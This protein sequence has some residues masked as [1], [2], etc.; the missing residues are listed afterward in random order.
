MYV[1]IIPSKA[2]NIATLTYSVPEEFQKDVEI[3]S[4]VEIPF[5]KGDMRG[6]VIEVT[7][8]APKFR[9]RP[10][11]GIPNI[12]I[13][14]ENVQ[15]IKWI[16]EYY[17][18]PLQ[19]AAKLFLPTQIWNK[20][21]KLPEETEENKNVGKEHD[22]QELHHRKCSFT[23]PQK[24]VFEDIK[25]SK[26]SLHLLHGVTGSGKT[27]V[28]LHLIHEQLEQGKQSLILLPEISLTPQTQKYFEN[29]FGENAVT[30]I[31]SG[32]TPKQRREAWIDVY[33]EKAKIIIGARSS[34]FAPFQKLGIIVVDES[35]DQSFKQDSSP[36][37]NAKRVAAE[38]AKLHNIQ[39]IYG[40]ATPN[41]ETYHAATKGTHIELNH[42]DEKVA[43]G[44]KRDIYMVDMKQEWQK[45]NFSI[46]S[47]LLIEKIQEKLDNK[48]QVI[49]FVNR[50]G[51]ASAMICK[52]CGYKA[53]CDACG[54]PLTYHKATPHTHTPT[55]QC[56]HCGLTKEPESSCPTCSGHNFKLT[57]VGTE[58]VEQEI[59]AH[60]P[61]A[62]T[63]RADSDTTAKQGAIKEIYD[64]FK[65]HK[66]DILIGTQMIA[67]GW[68][69]PNVT[70]VGIV[71]ADI[72]INIPDFR[73]SERIFQLL[74]QVAGRTARGDKHG[75]VVIQTYN[76]DN[77]TIQ[78]AAEDNYHKF[79]D[80]EIE[81]RKKF[82]FP[83]F[84]KIIKLIVSDKKLETC[85]KEAEQ[86]SEE[87]KKVTTQHPVKIYLA[88]DF[89]SYKAGKHHYN[90]FLQGKQPDEVLQKIKKEQLTEIKIDRI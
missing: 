30:V 5:R 24:K 23:K 13:S 72:G 35:H 36:R 75:D 55:L 76:P 33:T 19:A 80:G 8:K 59:Q 37:Y 17:F 79:Y 81:E 11:Q 61:K 1:E 43:K 49:L 68:N 56:H 58:K 69:I 66:A 46:F 50:R 65:D 84:A 42:I 70:L 32:Q 51:M 86:L 18:C 57:G 22:E 20:N 21:I 89:I 39:V 85:I 60:F 67:K 10:I 73:S 29:A 74:T 26:K 6:L 48:E 7:N 25:K 4:I 62:H 45:K 41:I 47:E 14:K 3:G 83:P 44:S 38:I 71:L 78:A 27:E 88:P 54:I 34:L 77:R 12:H 63:I 53:S 82:H 28:Y 15:L 64:S 9:T 40:S 52:D 90:V 87:L 2:C 31:H 16:S